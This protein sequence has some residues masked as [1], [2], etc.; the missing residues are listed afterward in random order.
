[1]EI[2]VYFMCKYRYRNSIKIYWIKF[3]LQ[4]NWLHLLAWL[5]KLP[6]PFW[7]VYQNSVV[8]CTVY[9]PERSSCTSTLYE[10][11]KRVQNGLYFY[12]I[13]EWMNNFAY[14]SSPWR[15]SHINTCNFYSFLRPNF[16]PL[17]QCP[18]PNLIHRVRP[19]IIFFSKE[20]CFAGVLPR[21]CTV[22]RASASA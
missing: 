18:V 12:R 4:L 1:M 3:N 17:V 19:T 13:L 22:P 15:V 11:S 6:R 14:K 20:K 10:E 16:L 5:T 21:G 8:R 9:V 7:I 2:S